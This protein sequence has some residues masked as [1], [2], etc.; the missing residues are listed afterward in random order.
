M[1]R[2]IVVSIFLLSASLPLMAARVQVQPRSSGGGGGA[3]NPPVAPSAP[4]TVS[5][6]RTH[7]QPR[8]N[9]PANYSPSGRTRV[10]RSAHP[11][12]PVP[13][14]YGS[15]RHWARYHG[16][17]YW[18]F[19]SGFHHWSYY[20]NGYWWWTA[21]SGVSYVYINNTYEPYAV[22]VV[23]VEPIG[24]ELTPPPAPDETTTTSTAPT[25]MTAADTGNSWRSPDNKRSKE[26]NTCL[27]QHRR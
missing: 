22:G 9:A 1:K 17:H 3:S 20:W 15:G 21:P 14:Y 26:G 7:V 8:T 4:T 24:Y 18:W 19:D 6:T 13:N 2:A 23:P 5:P 12:V 16:G 11:R 10:I 27:G 25:A